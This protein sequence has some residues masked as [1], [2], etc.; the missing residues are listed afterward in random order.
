MQQAAK[1]GQHSKLTHPNPRDKQGTATTR[2][3]AVLLPL[4]L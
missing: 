2:T 1:D 3:L 4:P